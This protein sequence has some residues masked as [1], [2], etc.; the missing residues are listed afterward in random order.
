MSDRVE[1]D[2][3][4]QDCNCPKRDG[5]VYHDRATCT[6]PVARRLSWYAGAP[7]AAAPRAVDDSTWAPLAHSTREALA[8]LGY[9]ILPRCLPDEPAACGGT[10]AQHT[11]AHLATMRAVVEHHV[12]HLGPSWRPMLEE[13]QATAAEEVSHW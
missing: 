11:A 5:R 13:I 7:A 6:D 8:L 2:N 3:G 9:D 12:T 1:M 10:F 4:Q